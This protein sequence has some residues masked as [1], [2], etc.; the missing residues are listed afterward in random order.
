M[1]VLL[2]D[3][4]LVDE[5]AGDEDEDDVVTANFADPKPEPVAEKSD[6][7]PEKSKS[8]KKDKKAKKK[9]KAAAKAT[10]DV[11]DEN[12]SAPPADDSSE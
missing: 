1:R 11:S 4:S 2:R 5:S 12:L 6:V 10:D 3:D 8:P 9:A 7:A